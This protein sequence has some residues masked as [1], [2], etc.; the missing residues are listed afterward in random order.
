MVTKLHILMVG[1]IL[2]QVTLLFSQDTSA[3]SSSTNQKLNYGVSLQVY[4]AGIIPT[5]NAELYRNEKY[6]WLFRV[7]AN[8]TDRRDFSD[9]HDEEKGGGFGGSIGYRRHFPLKNND[10]IIVGLNT[11][12][13]NLWINYKDD[14]GEPN[15]TSGRT[16]I[17]VLQP[18]L[19][20]GYFFNLKNSSKLGVTLGFGREFNVIT[21]GEEVEQ[22][23]I[24][25]ISLQYMFGR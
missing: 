25:S 11:D 4:P 10:K 12:L 9:F 15:E 21:R 22:D 2:F 1:F 13:W 14:V 8:L 19:E 23:L 18:Y 17:L 20:T 16:Y 7:G 5:V 3:S 24:G 6:S